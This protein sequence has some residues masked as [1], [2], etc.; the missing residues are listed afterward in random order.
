MQ[1][2]SHTVI[3]AFLEISAAGVIVGSVNWSYVHNVYDVYIF[4]DNVDDMYTMCMMTA[5]D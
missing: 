2:N 4:S 5:G 3:G 1:Y